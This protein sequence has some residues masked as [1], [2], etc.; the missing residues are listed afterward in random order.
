MLAIL[1]DLLHAFGFGGGNL[2]M[3]FDPVTMGLVLGGTQALGGVLQSVFSGTRKARK[4]YEEAMGQEGGELNS[5]LAQAKAKYNPN[6]YLSSEYQQR[7]NQLRQSQVQGISAAQDRRGGLATIG[8]LSES[9][10][11]GAAGAAGEAEAAQR[12]NY[13]Q[14]AQATGMYTEQQ[15]RK[16]NLLGQAYGQRALQQQ[17]G[18]QNIAGGLG[19]M[20]YS[21]YGDK[22]NKGFLPLSKGSGYGEKA[23]FDT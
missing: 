10:K 9:F 11:R 13:G 4:K 2:K 3:A 17:Q 7:M 8:A 1:Q 6:A 22:N 23:E 14:L 16:T 19:T 20:A 5:L 15:R 21:M 12:A 18:F